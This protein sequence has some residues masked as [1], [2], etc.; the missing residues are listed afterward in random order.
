[1]LKKINIGTRGS[2][3]ALF[4]ANLVK[5]TIV[6][7]FPDYSVE[8]KIYKTQGDKILDVA[9]SKI[10]DKGLFTKELE[11]ALLSKEIDIAVHSLKDLPTTLP[12]GLTLAAVLP[13]AEFRDVIISLN[14]TTTNTF[15]SSTRVATSSLRR[16]AGVLSI[17]SGIIL[18]DIRGN[19]E[20][21]IKK[22]SD[23]YC[24]ALIM[25]AAG[26]QRLGLD[27]YISQIIDPEIITPAVS[28]G[29]IGIEAREN[30]SEFQEIFTA[31]NHKSTH[32]MAVAERDFLRSLE[33]GCQVPIG[34]YSNI[35]KETFTLHGFVASVDGKKTLRSK[36]T[37]PLND[38][39]KI[40]TLLADEMKT[41]GARDILNSICR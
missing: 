11:L 34:A 18:L 35:S 2:K 37:L 31:I 25:A 12:Y 15:T 5:D 14:N 38:F 41:S 10:G 29:I 27:S 16:Q 3:L 6:E 9:L 39:K 32:M 7:Q 1:M 24:D 4:Q 26:V 17:C 28:Q 36:M 33:G 40:G 22:M 20:T 13:R 21:R 19:V 30:D 23:G 8:I